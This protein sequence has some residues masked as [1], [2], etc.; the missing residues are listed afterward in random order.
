[1]TASEAETTLEQ[2]ANE[3]LRSAGYDECVRLLDSESRSQQDEFENSMGRFSE[4]GIMKQ[5]RRALR[6]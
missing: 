1:M 3:I 2:K 4:P 5:V 6:S